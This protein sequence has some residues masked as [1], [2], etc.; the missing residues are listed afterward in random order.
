M[1]AEEAGNALYQVEALPGG[2]GDIGRVFV[3]FM[4]M[5]TGQMVERSWIIPYDS[6]TANIDSTTPSMQ[7]A[8]VAGLLGEKMKFGES[9]GINLSRLDQVT[10]KLRV[11]Y[12]NDKKVKA[13]LRMVER[14]KR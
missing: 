12:H 14:T 8:S 5:E 13:L 4:D 2:R 11:H 9:A 3:R 10:G 1:A 6:Q 7:L